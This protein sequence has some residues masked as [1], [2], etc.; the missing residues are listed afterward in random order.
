MIHLLFIACL[1]AVGVAQ[2]AAIRRL[3]RRKHAEDGKLGAF[4]VAGGIALLTTAILSRMV[5]QPLPLWLGIGA[6]ILAS[7]AILVGI[8]LLEARA[9]DR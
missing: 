5:G 6:S 2:V 8:G 1:V 9:R 7:S 3:V 4:L